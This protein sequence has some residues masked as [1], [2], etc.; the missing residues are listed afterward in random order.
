MDKYKILSNAIKLAN[1]K[2]FAEAKKEIFKADNVLNANEEIE[3]YELLREAVTFY[4]Y[5]ETTANGN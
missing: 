4:V 5:Y 2:K 1:D 3:S